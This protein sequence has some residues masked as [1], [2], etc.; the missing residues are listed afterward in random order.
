[1]NIYLKKTLVAAG[2]MALAA[3]VHAQGQLDWIDG[4]RGFSIAIISPDLVNST[5]EFTG[6]TT[7]DTP[8]SS[9]NYTGGWI[10]GTA[11]APGGGGPRR[12]RACGL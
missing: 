10:G 12:Q 1:M 2:M 7:W 8:S 3:G 6:N 4:Q 11:V 5:Q 9:A